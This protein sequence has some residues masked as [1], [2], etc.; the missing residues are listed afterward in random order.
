MERILDVWCYPVHSVYIWILKLSVALWSIILLWPSACKACAAQFQQLLPHEQYD[1]ELF[2]RTASNLMDKHGTRT[3][4][5]DLVARA[6]FGYV[7]E[8]GHLDPVIS[9]NSKLEPLEQYIFLHHEAIHSTGAHNLI[10][11]PSHLDNA[12]IIL[13]E[14][15]SGE[16]APG[17]K[18]Y[19]GRMWMEEV[20]ANHK[21]KVLY[22]QL[23][24]RY[25]SW[26]ANEMMDDI[27]TNIADHAQ[28]LGRISE[29]SISILDEVRELMT[30]GGEVVVKPVFHSPEHPEIIFFRFS[31]P[32]P[33][34]D[35]I[36]VAIPLRI[37]EFQKTL[38]V[39]NLS[40]RIV[41]AI[42][43]A[44]RRIRHWSNQK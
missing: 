26:A 7:R 39:P 4:L 22:Q 8:D 43:Q 30:G 31:L 38:E 1:A 18:N 33:D 6:D 14:R 11:K 21:T 25:H 19:S 44:K 32:R 24:R 36:T 23:A 28:I 16:I 29:V 41:E 15:A 5:T 27:E 9:V 37:P 34:G 10:H 2:S 12:L 17:M 3:V 20:K 13:V 42:E 35:P 40:G